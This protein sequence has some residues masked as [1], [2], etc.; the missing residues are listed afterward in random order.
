M[1]P[2]D[3]THTTERPRR[4]DICGSA[5]VP[6]VRRPTAQ[7]TLF[8]GPAKS[9]KLP[10]PRASQRGFTLI[11]ALIALVILSLGLF[12][13]MQIQT[14]VIAGT[15]DSKTQTTAVNLAQEKL[16]ELRAS[17]YT[18]IAG[19]TDRIPAAAG[20]T[21]DFTRTWTVT[22]KTDPP[23][24]VVS[25]TTTWTR[26]RQDTRDAGFASVTLTT[27]I[28]RSTLSAL[29]PVGEEPTVPPPVNGGGLSPTVSVNSPY[30]QCTNSA[31]PCSI[32]KNATI[33]PSFIVTDDAAL[34]TSNLSITASGNGASTSGSISYNAEKAEV[35]QSILT[36]NGNNKTFSVVMR[37][38]DGVNTT[39]VTLHFETT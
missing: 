7:A 21:T 37:A 6:P 20:G 28:A 3:L 31:S 18:A 36:P 33:S 8:T 2:T 29:D 39:T 23:Y 11:E 22:P 35:S 26:A 10:S 19:G 12:G 9:P 14:R 17:D 4:P 24:L 13:L 32:A 1:R 27:Y 16:E 30:S 15:G 38:N 25:V 5:G 34:S